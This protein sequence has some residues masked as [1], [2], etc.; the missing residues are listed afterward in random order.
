MLNRSTIITFILLLATMAFF[1]IFDLW[2]ERPHPLHVW[3]NADC[4]SIT[5]NYYDEGM[6]FGEP[7]IHN[8]ISDDDTSGKTAGEFPGWY[9]LIALLWKIFGVNEGLYRFAVGGF[10]VI[11]LLVLQSAARRLIGDFWS[12]LLTVWLFVQPALVYYAFAFLSNVPALS[13][14]LLGL[15]SFIRY[16]IHGSKKHLYWMSFF[17]ALAGLFK[18]TALLT[19]C[20]I[21]A[22]LL[23]EWVGVGL[24]P[25]RKLFR[26]HKRDLLVMA[27]ALLPNFIW[28]T[29]A[30]WYNG[31]H[32]GKYTFNGLW[33]LWE[34]DA[35]YRAEVWQGI[36]EFVGPQ[37]MSPV[38]WIIA[39]VTTF[40]GIFFAKRIPKALW[41]APII[42]FLGCLI[43]SVFWFQAWRNHDYYFIN[44]YVWPLIA[45]G[46]I[47]GVHKMLMIPKLAERIFRAVGVLTL[48]WSFWYGQEHLELRI[49]PDYDKDY[50]T[51]MEQEEGK[52]KYIF[53]D[54]DRHERGLLDIEPLLAD[55]G[56]GEDDL[57]VTIPDA[58]YSITLYLMDRKGWSNMV[59]R[60]RD[61]ES[62]RKHI[63]KGAKY[64][65]INEPNY[66]DEFPWVKEFMT[67]LVLEHR[68][69]RVY[70]LN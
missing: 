1:G 49:A 10:F 68:S 27:V 19:Y 31:I 69:I 66:E 33:P 32:G 20:T 24:W 36:I 8:Y 43:Y 25:D 29:W 28:Y 59:N 62:L 37:I 39:L 44:V 30:A 70:R 22:L 35:S 58:S 42:L 11:S 12:V 55:A 51:A 40:L 18:V 14:A 60:N 41:L 54:H 56:V 34:A 9:Y 61:A 2:N 45:M 65:V 46:C 64:L 26:N 13:F 52:L 16:A 4:L 3:R 53:W 15:A 48:A 21:G 63:A 7:A 38:N 47:V 6:N 57:V 17:Y 5:Q 50:F 67:D 23:L